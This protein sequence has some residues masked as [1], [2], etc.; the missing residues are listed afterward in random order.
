[1]AVYNE[2]LA[3]RFNR[4]LQKLF[5]MKGPPPVPQLGSEIL[6]V[7][8]L[9]F[10]SENRYLEGWNRFAGLVDSPA[11]AANQSAIRVRNPKSNQT[12]I[13]F[14]KILIQ[15]YVANKVSTYLGA[16]TVDLA[17]PASAFVR[18]DPRGPAN[19]GMSVSS[20]NTSPTPPLPGGQINQFSVFAAPNAPYDQIITDVQEITLLPGDA[21][22]VVANTVNT[23]LTC[24]FM[25]RERVLEDSETT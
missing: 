13:I 1:M 25:W 8:P 23:E 11:V 12:I 9:F 15:V 20:Q 7:L 24:S 2:I 19:S 10:G 4:A 5:S 18:L 22:Q 16:G 14:E 17:T 3:G 21:L 6:A